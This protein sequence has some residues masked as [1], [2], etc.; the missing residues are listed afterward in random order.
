M[1]CC[2]VVSVIPGQLTRI[3]LPVLPV[4]AVLLDVMLPE[5]VFC[6]STVCDNKTRRGNQ[7]LNPQSTTVSTSRLP[8]VLLF[9]V[10]SRRL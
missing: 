10:L 8:I 9:Y 7:R 5:V 4:A 1:V 6:T 2:S 3:V